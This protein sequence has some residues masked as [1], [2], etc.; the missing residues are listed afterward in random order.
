[1]KQMQ[2]VTATVLRLQTPLAELW[3][4]LKKLKEDGNP[5]GIIMVLII[6]DLLSSQKLS[7]QPKSIHGLVPGPWHICNRGICLLSVVKDSPNS[8]VET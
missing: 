3:E 4:G 8:P 1:M 6:P 5:T 2:T 7:Y